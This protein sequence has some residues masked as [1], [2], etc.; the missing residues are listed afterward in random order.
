MQDELSFRRAIDNAMTVGVA[1]IDRE[2]RQSYVNAA[3]CRMVG[4]SEQDLVGALPPY[5]YW[6]PE[7]SETI[8]AA[9]TATLRGAAPADGFE[10][11]FRRADDT[12]FRALFS[13]APLCDSGGEVTGWVASMTDIMERAQ[14]QKALQESELKLRILFENAREAIG[15]ATKGKIVFV[16]PAYARLLGYASPEEMIGMPA[17]DPVAPADRERLTQMA[18]LRKAGIEVPFAYEYRGRKK[19]GTECDLENHV[20][21]YELNGQVYT[22]VTTRDITKRKQQEIARQFLSEA[23]TV[24]ASSLDYEKTLQQVANLAVPHIAD[25][26]GVDMLADDGSIHQLAVAHVNPEKV[27]WGHELRRRYPPNMD[28]QRGLVNVMRTGQ[29]E[30]YSHIPDELL[31]LGARDAEHL[32]M[33][34]QIGIDSLMIV[35]MIVRERILGAITFVATDE[36]G[37]HY[38]EDDLVLAEGLAER[39]ALAIDNA[40]LYRAAQEELIERTRIQEALHA[41]EERFRFALANSSIIVYTQDRDLHYTWVYN[42]A[43]HEEETHV[44]GMTDADLLIAEDALPLIEIKRRVLGSGTEERHIIRATP[45][46]R[47][48]FYLDISFV[49]LRD[50]DGSIV[51]ITGTA[52]NITE[53]KQAQDALAQHQAEI[54]ALNVRLQRS[55]RETHHRVKNN[56]QVISALVNMQQMQY[57]D[58]VPTTELQRLTH[59]IQALASIHDL[60]THQAQTD[61]DVSDI[62]I[63]GVMEKLMPTVQGMVKGRQITFDVKDMRLPVR[64]STTFAVLVNELVSNALKHGAGEIHVNFS[65]ADNIAVLQVLDEGAGF[66]PGFDPFMAAN[67]GLDLIDSLARMDMHGSVRYENRAEGGARV[68]VEFDVTELGKTSTEP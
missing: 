6:P 50:P 34:R 56:L 17:L 15:I 32:E 54:E 48:P 40:R 26:C 30:I 31:A 21:S 8:M 35:P 46:G 14:T 51:G 61:A 53:R 4:S 19:D 65:V 62:S 66:P 18:H 22:I 29:S 49:P 28:D 68:V 67:T 59:H 10:L 1:V 63:Q 44:Y 43:L 45:P 20:A 52:N 60:L 3:F 33:M 5:A 16:N 36:S 41:S 47:Q 38:T 7:E 27:R 55:M 9:F 24:L 2:G 13:P 57:E 37:H 25:W 42:G 58:Q 12:R 64:Q 39:A 23:S 11:T